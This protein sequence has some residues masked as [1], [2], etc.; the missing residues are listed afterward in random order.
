MKIMKIRILLTNFILAG[1]GGCAI[2]S[3]PQISI[4]EEEESVIIKLGQPTHRYQVGATICS[5]SRKIR[6]DK[7]LT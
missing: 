1:V 6:G 4:G 7:K 2:F 3:Q 5:N